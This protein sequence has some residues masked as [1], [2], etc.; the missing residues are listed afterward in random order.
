MGDNSPVYSHKCTPKLKITSFGEKSVKR[1]PQA[2]KTCS[3]Q[4]RAWVEG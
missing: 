3:L 4:L 2:H 1:L